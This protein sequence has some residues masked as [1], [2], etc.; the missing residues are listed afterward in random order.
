MHKG[1]CV[2]CIPLLIRS[3]KINMGY[4]FFSHPSISL[5]FSLVFSIF[6]QIRENFPITCITQLSL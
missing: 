1:K 2:G 4:F 6:K 5:L 3:C